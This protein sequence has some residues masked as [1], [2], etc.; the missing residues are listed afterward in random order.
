[1]LDDFAPR[2][3]RGRPAKLTPAQVEEIR[4]WWAVYEGLPTCMD[5]ARKLKVNEKTIYAVARGMW[6]KE[7]YRERERGAAIVQGCR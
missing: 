3:R 4:D 7:T 2:R 6:H 5:M 1:M